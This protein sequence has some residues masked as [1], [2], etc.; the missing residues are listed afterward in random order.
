MLRGFI[1]S[2]VG[3][4]TVPDIVPN[5][6]ISH[7]SQP[8]P[9]KAD[10]EVW[11]VSHRDI[12]ASWRSIYIGEYKVHIRL[13]QCEELFFVLFLFQVSGIFVSCLPPLF[14]LSINC[15]FI[16][17]TASIHLPHILLDTIR[18]IHKIIKILPYSISYQIKSGRWS[19]T[20][21]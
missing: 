19:P 11:L 15:H 4:C 18:K 8:H 17:L 2:A 6:S 20:N 12:A 1:A 16:S 5:A 3:S 13:L 14:F 21:K 9:H 7:G 10:A